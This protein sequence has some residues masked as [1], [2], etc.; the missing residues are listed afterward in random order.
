[1]DP[2]IMK[3]DCDVDASNLH[4]LFQGK[5]LIKKPFY[6]AKV[7]SIDSQLCQSC[8]ICY[9]I[10]R[11]NGISKTLMVDPFKCEGC[12]ACQVVCPNNAISLN[13]EKT[14]HTYLT[15]T[16]IGKLSRA[17][18]FPGAEGS[19]KL[20]SEV[21]K[22]ASENVFIDGSPGIGCTVM[23]SI[24][25]VDY[26]IIITEPSYSGYE[27]LKRVYALTQHFNIQSFV[28]INKYDIHLG[29]SKVI[30]DY[31]Q[32][33]SIKLL[34]KIPFDQT[35]STAINAGQVIS[36]YD[37]PASQAIVSI[38]EAFKKEVIL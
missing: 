28:V 17:N 32:E 25:G 7:A 9:E 36:K 6:G 30:D 23:A 11:F 5:D 26:A 3:M 37:S 22:A 8:Q 31:C 34:G 12:G 24:T 29:L 18:L 13:R 35:V 14:G 20:V 2:S 10:C 27:D 16:E 33:Q 1:M 4:L 15:D 19:G 21:R 38:Y